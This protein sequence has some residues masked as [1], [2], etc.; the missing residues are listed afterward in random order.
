GGARLIPDTAELFLGFTSTQKAGLGPPGIANFETLP[1]YT[2]QFPDGY[3]LGGTAMHLSHL[4][5][6]V[7]ACTSISIIPSAWRR[8]SSPGSTSRRG[9]RR[10]P[11]TPKTRTDRRPTSKM[12]SNSTP[13]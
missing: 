5:E 4:F 6:D 12:P 9:R 2:N 1:G 8:P 11:R 3:F 7:E 13:S 10:S